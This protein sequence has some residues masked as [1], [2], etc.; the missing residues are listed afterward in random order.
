MNSVMLVGRLLFHMKPRLE[1]MASLWPYPAHVCFPGPSL[2]CF[3][4]EL[5]QL[6]PLHPLL[7]LLLV[8]AA[9]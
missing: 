6:L 2:L 3:L 8:A 7:L 1:A 9:L 5:L 4:L